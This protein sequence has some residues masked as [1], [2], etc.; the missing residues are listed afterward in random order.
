MLLKKF[1]GMSAKQIKD[2]LKQQ[3]PNLPDAAA[4][5]IA[6]MEANPDKSNYMDFLT[7]VDPTGLAAIAK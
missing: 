7:K 5:K 2:M 3:D 6:E 1:A 4:Q